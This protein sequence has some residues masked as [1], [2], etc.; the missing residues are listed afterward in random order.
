MIRGREPPSWSMMALNPPAELAGLG[1]AY[2]QLLEDVGGGVRRLAGGQDLLEALVELGGR[3]LADDGDMVDAIE[4]K[5]V[6]RQIDVL[7]G[8]VD[9]GLGLTIGTAGRLLAGK[10][11]RAG[12][13]LGLVLGLGAPGSLW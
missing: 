12:V 7:T 3:W 4:M 10:A 1:A 5:A 2:Q 8:P 13:G 9:S 6:G 11:G